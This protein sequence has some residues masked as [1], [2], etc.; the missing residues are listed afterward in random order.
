MPTKT[1]SVRTV[2]NLVIGDTGNDP[3]NGDADK[4]TLTGDSENDQLLASSDTPAD[5]L[6]DGTP[7]GRKERTTSSEKTVAIETA[8]PAI[9]SM[10]PS[11]NSIEE[12]C[13]RSCTAN[14]NLSIAVSLK[15][16]SRRPFQKKGRAP[17]V[18]ARPN[19]AEHYTTMQLYLSPFSFGLSCLAAAFFFSADFRFDSSFAS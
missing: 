3:L 18:R 1:P 8:V 10:I 9:S 5:S 4:N 7:G 2:N 11:P 17:P 16:V 13:A 6:G 14:K 12:R 19:F 15:I